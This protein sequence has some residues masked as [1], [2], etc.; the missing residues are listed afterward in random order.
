MKASKPA[1]SDVVTCPLC[2]GHGK[3]ERT[4]VVTRLNEEEFNRTLQNY[5]DEVT[6]GA[7]ELR[8]PLAERDVVT[9]VRAGER[10]GAASHKK[11]GDA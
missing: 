9:L 10:E 7:M 6:Y 11:K 2:E 1:T 3:L 8:D 4:K 5:I